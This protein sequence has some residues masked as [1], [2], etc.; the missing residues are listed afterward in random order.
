MPSC[1]R[2]TLVDN[3]ALVAMPEPDQLA[4]CPRKCRSAISPDPALEGTF[5]ERRYARANTLT[6]PGS[7]LHSRTVRPWSSTSRGR[8]PAS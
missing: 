1:R 5:D 4:R 3:T 8:E 6:R 2:E 7:P